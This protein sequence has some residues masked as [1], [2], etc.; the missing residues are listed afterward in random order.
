MDEMVTPKEEK[1]T[2]D[3]ADANAEFRR[4]I[5]MVAAL[6]Q[7]VQRLSEKVD[8]LEHSPKQ[9]KCI[10]CPHVSIRIPI[11]FPIN[12]PLGNISNKRS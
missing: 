6:T 8:E 7:E 11:N 10:L 1:F 9:E 2:L 5:E 3:N 4:L 12:I